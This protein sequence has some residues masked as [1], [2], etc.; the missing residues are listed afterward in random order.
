MALAAWSAGLALSAPA[1]ARTC[2][3]LTTGVPQAGTWTGSEVDCFTLDVPARAGA[4]KER[5]NVWLS[6]VTGGK[7]VVLTT[8]RKTVCSLPGWCTV[9]TDDTYIVETRR[10]GPTTPTQSHPYELLVQSFDRPARCPDLGR[11]TNA[12]VD[13]VI[14]RFGWSCH[15]FEVRG[16]RGE[17]V[18]VPE[19]GFHQFHVTDSTGKRCEFTDILY[20]DTAGC[21]LGPGKYQIVVYNAR[22]SAPYTVAFAPLPPSSCAAL[23]PPFTFP[24]DVRES[25]G[26]AFSP[27]YIQGTYRGATVDCYRFPVY[28]PTSIYTSVITDGALGAGRR[29]RRPDGSI[30]CSTASKVPS[31]CRATAAGTYT[32]ETWYRPTADADERHAYKLAL[33]LPGASTDGCLDVSAPGAWAGRRKLTSEAVDCYA[34]RVTEVGTVFERKAGDPTI[35]IYD[36]QR[37][38][39]C[40]ATDGPCALALGSY[41]VVVGGGYGH[42]RFAMHRPVDDQRTEC[43]KATSVPVAFDDAPLVQT[44]TGSEHDCVRFQGTEGQWVSASVAWTGDGRPGKRI[45]AAD[46]TQVCRSGAW[47][48][49]LCQLPAT[50][51]YYLESWRQPPL[52]DGQTTVYRVDLRD[53]APWEACQHVGAGGTLSGRRALITNHATCYRISLERTWHVSF[54]PGTPRMLM[55]DRVGRPICRS[56]ATTPCRRSGLAYLF[57]TGRAGDYAFTV[58]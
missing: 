6:D 8:G 39:Q 2:P 18:T 48:P 26:R 49:L 46:G 14:S 21:R 11:V 56:A 1:H 50:G 19:R 36:A 52:G 38:E 57:V 7:V 45:I 58:T 32:V 5:L 10:T 40:V 34:V 54:A 13:G 22:V 41:T 55:V 27:G 12:R 24:T 43:S 29:I 53:F 30:L 28:A 33:Q 44:W 15:A 35:R 20:P 37:N 17:L 51:R 25:G 23:D 3:A 47:A 42:W 16:N 9:G 31:V 4:T